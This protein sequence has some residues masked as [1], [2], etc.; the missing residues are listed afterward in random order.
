M[1]LCDGDDRVIGWG[2]GVNA[3]TAMRMVDRLIVAGFVTRRD[4]PTN[5]REVLL[6]LTAAGRRI[7]QK[8]T[9]RRRTEISKVVAAMPAT[10]R[11][12]IVAALRAFSAA[13]EEPSVTVRVNDD[14]AW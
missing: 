2:L 7:V 10:R 6:G 11:T 9:V 8:V 14:L 1:I 5:R 4:N 3:S 13:A 12:Q